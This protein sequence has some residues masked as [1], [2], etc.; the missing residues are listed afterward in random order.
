MSIFSKIADF[1]SPSKAK[2]KL[3]EARRQREAYLAEKKKKEEEAKKKAA[4]KTAAAKQLQSTQKADIAKRL[5]SKLAP[6][7]ARREGFLTRQPST[8][9]STQATTRER[10]KFVFPD[11]NVSAPGQSLRADL[12]LV[13]KDK[14][15]QTI[16]VTM[17]LKSPTGKIT[18]YVQTTEKV[19]PGKTQPYG[20]EVRIPDKA[21]NGEWQ[22]WATVNG[23]E[24]P[25]SRKKHTVT[26]AESIDRY[27]SNKPSITR[28][29]G[30]QETVT[31][32][33]LGKLK[34]IQERR[35]AQLTKQQTPEYK[36]ALGKS[37]ENVFMNLPR[38]TLQSGARIAQSV[39]SKLEG[40]PIIPFTPKTKAA[41]YLLGEEPIGGV[42]QAGEQV[43]LKGTSAF[44][45]GGLLS[46]ADFWVGGGGSK[47]AKLIAKSDSVGDIIKT[48]KRLFPKLEVE[49]VAPLARKLVTVSDEAE[50]KNI[51]QDVIKPKTGSLMAAKAT[52]SQ[53]SKIPEEI[54]PGSAGRLESEATRIGQ[55][56]PLT[57]ELAGQVVQPH[58][59][60]GAIGELSSGSGI[61]KIRGLVK[62]LLE[63]PNTPKE[64]K[65][66]ISG[67]YTVR[68]TAELFEKANAFVREFP[69]EAERILD[70]RYYDDA[71]NAI[72]SELMVTYQNV[73][74]FDDA[75]RIVQKLS[76]RATEQGR[77][78]QALS[79]YGKFTPEGILRFAQKEIDRFNDTVTKAIHLTPATA[80]EL[81]AKST[82]I[83]TMVDGYD[84]N[85]AVQEMLKTVKDIFPD[86]WT[87]KV[88]T[89]Q[90][91]AQLLNPKTFIRNIGGNTIFGGAEHV[92]QVV[93]VPLDTAI[94]WVTGGR[95]RLAPGVMVKAKGLVKGSK[96]A[97]REAM[98]GVSV[99]PNTQY[100]L[101]SVRT[102]W[103]T[104]G[105]NGWDKAKTV[106]NRILG[107]LETSMNVALRVPDKAAFKA[108]FDN[109]LLNATKI[110]KVSEPT[111]EM[112][113]AA[114]HAGLYATFQD[115]N[116]LSK[117][118]VG[119]K[120]LLNMAG[121]NVRGSRFGVGDMILK[122]PKTPSNLIA[123]GLDYSPAG[124]V[125][126]IFE[127]SKPLFG[128]AFDQGAF[129]DNLSRAIVGTGG[130][131]TTGYVLR[132]MG[133]I[134]AEPEENRKANVLQKA[135]GIGQ[136]R[137]NVSALKRL[138]LSFDARQGRL[139]PDD[140]LVS[141]DWAQ[142]LSM[143]LAMG[144]NMADS[145]QDTDPASM[146]LDMASAALETVT[147]QPLVSGL[148]QTLQQRDPVQMLANVA[149]DIPSSFVPTFFNQL[150]QV[151]DNTSR[152][153]Y[154]GPFWQQMLNQVKARIPGLYETIPSQAD[155][156]GRQKQ[157]YQD[158]SN[159][160]FN[161]F[162]NPAF[163]SKY[164]PT[165]EAQEM[166]RL[167]STTG[168]AGQL[169]REIGKSIDVSGTTIK[170]GSV[171]KRRLQTYIGTKTVSGMA[172]LMKS[173]EYLNYTD[174]QKVKVVANIVSDV[175]AAAKIKFLGSKAYGT[176]ASVQ[177]IVSGRGFIFSKPR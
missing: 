47:A 174:E 126:V 76:P 86:A 101:N 45:V 59:Q 130:L 3:E 116:L 39:K 36:K 63:S 147:N 72:A 82:K 54:L 150:R 67:M 43:G 140:T 91:M 164:K 96:Q 5:A 48:I 141:Y 62:S 172:T 64:V 134:T 29:S 155:V 55:T 88:A 24:V 6:V 14:K 51:I 151:S 105:G 68:N 135:I 87:R 52:K 2:G 123:R 176:D 112:I 32:S 162:F 157:V 70:S 154:N 22:V 136:Y 119:T 10:E 65:A 165:P 102:H 95:T 13:N 128:V 85:F 169:P 20:A 53:L 100:D 33:R 129:V 30:T 83:K 26:K 160:I 42:A 50:V 40:K 4:E 166:L 142:P 118:F 122:Y 28:T 35:T 18:S 144:A 143:S 37:G 98:A 7:Q 149:V 92:S 170:L 163:V 131:V 79:L 117:F 84:K 177:A 49:K 41:K 89:L 113:D 73:G 74:R 25:G 120:K 115:T 77:A 109:H 8:N 148:R 167:F 66:G 81:V 99:G 158:N 93:A 132:K 106:G 175:V 27:T 114:T 46:A 124:F 153:V 21:E 1:F 133:V 31:D 9:Q 138:I 156:L 94:S 15:E 34:S 97:W 57:S 104:L 139:K 23:K 44:L 110:A 146:A 173:S 90:T 137:V 19:A 125:K 107:G 108:A 56:T 78:V 103:F 152:D 127:A 69:V 161:V 71:S 16:K 11:Y 159:N 60:P 145:K 61:T 75:I 171:Q 121:F 111:A 12:N 80:E 58:I 17:H 38:Y 168:E